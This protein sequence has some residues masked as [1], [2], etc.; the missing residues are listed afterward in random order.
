MKERRIVE[1]DVLTP[2][3]T[4]R[5]FGNHH[6]AAT[7]RPSEMI[8]R[9][10]PPA[11]ELA[12]SYL[13]VKGYFFDLVEQCCGSCE[14]FLYQ[15]VSGQLEV[16][17]DAMSVDEERRGGMATYLQ[18]ALTVLGGAGFQRARSSGG[19]MAGAYLLGHRFGFEFDEE[20]LSGFGA[21]TRL[22]EGDEPGPLPQ[23]GSQQV[24]FLIARLIAAAVRRG[25]ISEDEAETIRLA[26]PRSPR[27]LAGFPERDLSKR[28]LSTARYPQVK[29]L[30]VDTALLPG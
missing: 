13:P 5:D 25:S 3:F 24:E 22:A 23:E 21:R 28:L 9:A 26:N 6:L 30:T 15:S 16:W 1:H 8:G 19:G 7:L 11:P 10:L 14:F 4:G 12:S 17:L 27:A 29:D 18:H 2:A 20:R